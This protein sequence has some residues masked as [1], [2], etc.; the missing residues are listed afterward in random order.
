MLN[1]LTNFFNLLAIGRFKKELEDTDVLAVGTQTGRRVGSYKPTA[2]Q[3]KDLKEQFIQL[4]AQS[5]N[6]S[7]FKVAETLIS[8]ET[9]TTY[10]ED[11]GEINLFPQ[12][13]TDTMSELKLEY[14]LIPGYVDILNEFGDPLENFLIEK[15]EFFPFNNQY[16]IVI[17]GDVT[18]DY[19]RGDILL[20]DIYDDINDIVLTNQKRKIINSVYSEAVNLPQPSTLITI[21]ISDYAFFQNT[22]IRDTKS[23]LNPKISRHFGN[24]EDFVIYWSYILDMSIQNTPLN[25]F[26][27]DSIRSQSLDNYA[28]NLK[29]NNFGD[30]T[31]GSETGTNQTRG[32]VDLLVRAIYKDA[33]LLSEVDTEVK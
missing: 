1:N 4:V 21:N 18:A 7:E 28:E 22:P 27:F 12:L 32:T 13:N 29:N 14:F 19:Q 2:I 17:P 31:L 30:L 24:T 11:F 5:G 3:V 15:A 9:L 33:P 26:L 16:F 25:A 10:A 6:G 20:F 23:L 8:N